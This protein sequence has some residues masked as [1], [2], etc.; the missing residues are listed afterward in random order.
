M[1][2]PPPPHLPTYLLYSRGAQALSS[3]HH[4]VVPEWEKLTQ[5]QS[6]AFVSM[7]SLMDPSLAPEGRHVIH[8]YLPA[9]EPYEVW[10]G[11]AR[12]TPAY[13]ALKAERAAPLYAAIERFIPDVRD[14]VEIELIGSPLTHERFLRRHRGTY[15]PEL[16][17][18]D[19]AFPGAKTQV[20]APQHPAPPS[21]PPPNPSSPLPQPWSLAPTFALTLPPALSCPRPRPNPNQVDGLLCCGDSCWPG[22]GVPAVAGSGI[23]AAHVVTGPVAQ[24]ELLREMRE[25]GTLLPAL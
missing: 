21:A 1:V 25:R 8:A 13:D 16:S 17:A 10:E 14:R 18:A 19:S 12:G 5:P 9:T 3:I 22:I 11:V 24:R 20:D 6:A 15:G 4:I 7:P 2:A 23:A